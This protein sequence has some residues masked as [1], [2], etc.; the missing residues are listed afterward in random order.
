MKVALDVSALN[1]KFKEHSIRGIGRYVREIHAYLSNNSNVD[2]KTFD[3]TML[4]KEYEKKFIDMLPMGKQS[5]SQQI[6]IPSKLR[7]IYKGNVDFIH[8]PSH[9]DCPLFSPKPYIITVLDLI[10]LIFKDLYDQGNYRAKFARWLEI[11]SIKNADFLIAISECTAKDIH[12]ILNIPYEKIRVTHLGV[13]GSFF[14]FQDEK[15]LEVNFR[16]Q[17]N[18]KENEKIIL[19][20]GG[21]DQR[22]NYQTLLKTI[23]VLKDKYKEKKDFCFKLVMVGKI[24]QDKQY[25]NYKKLIKENNI[26]DLVLEVGFLDD[27]T[28]K[29]LYGFSSVLFFPSLYEG[30]GLTP[31]EAMARGLPVVCSNTHAVKEVVKDY[32]LTGEATD[33]KNF[34]KLIDEVF[35]NKNLSKKLSEE[36]ILR[37][38]IFTWEKTGEKTLEVYEE[39]I[40]K[41][42]DENL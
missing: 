35:F 41:I 1:P 7:K 3:Q 14:N 26:E 22:K 13:D 28:L 8:F 25:E 33:A 24:N 5:I 6:F 31:L 20:V 37:A 27:F 32:A 30:F 12:K 2:L 10:Y 34:A 42:N 16:K 11:K 21:I 40:K 4:L 36:G 39:L 23:A 9:T 18:L 29:S 19:Y 17:Y 15:I 38:K